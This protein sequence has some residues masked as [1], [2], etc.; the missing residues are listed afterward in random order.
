MSNQKC[1]NC[2]F[3]SIRPQRVNDK[4]FYTSLDKEKRESINKNDFIWQ[5]DN[6]TLCCYFSVWDDGYNPEK[7]D[8]RKD[9]TE[10]E[11]KDFCFFWEYH[12][13]MIVPIAKILQERE[14]AYKAIKTERRLTIIAILIA[15][16]AL[17]VSI[18]QTYCCK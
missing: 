18:V 13:G 7:L 5:N 3:L 1:I 4:N 11:R 9:I 15:S 16:F 6:A 14:S 17:I 8:L 10:K 2:H 12:P